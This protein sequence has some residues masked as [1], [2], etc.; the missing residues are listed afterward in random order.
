MNIAREVMLKNRYRKGQIKNILRLKIK[1]ARILRLSDKLD[2]LIKGKC[3]I[4]G[5]TLKRHAL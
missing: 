2:I 4:S 5:V 1:K 3:V